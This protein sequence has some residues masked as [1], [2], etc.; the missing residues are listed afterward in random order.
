[1]NEV[2]TYEEWPTPT[3]PPTFPNVVEAVHT[4]CTAHPGAI[5]QAKTYKTLQAARGGITR[6]DKAKAKDPARFTGTWT[7]RAASLDEPLDLG[8]GLTHEA[9]IRAQHIPAKEAK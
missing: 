6:L 2:I 5:V 9:E 3:V 8:D 7:W 1:M 4:A